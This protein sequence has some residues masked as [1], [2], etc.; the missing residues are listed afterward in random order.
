MKTFQ[1][2]SKPVEKVARLLASHTSLHGLHT[3]YQKVKK[4]TQEEIV[5]A[6]Q[7]ACDEL[8]VQERNKKPEPVTGQAASVKIVGICKYGNGFETQAEITVNGVIYYKHWSYHHT[9]SEA[10]DYLDKFNGTE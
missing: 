8:Y 2:C 9:L 5:E 7:A 3:V 1:S 6:Y 10:E 4:L